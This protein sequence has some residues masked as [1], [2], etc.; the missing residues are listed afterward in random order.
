MATTDPRVALERERI[1]LRTMLDSL[2][3]E[4]ANVTSDG[5]TF[6][7]TGSADQHPADMGTE[8]FELEKDLSIQS[9]LEASLAD[10]EW[11]LKRV[12]DG[13]YGTC[14]T[15]KRRIPKARL[16]AMPGT[17]YCLDDQQR[18]ERERRAA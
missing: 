15:C 1:R 12:D 3:R 8:T 16:Q 2:K 5:D 18:A 17:R 14:E 13:T 11:A 10:V 7:E 9:T 6:S 4:T